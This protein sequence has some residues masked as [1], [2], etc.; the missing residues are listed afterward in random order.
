MRKSACLFIIGLA[1]H[2]SLG[3]GDDQSDCEKAGGVWNDP[4]C[5]GASHQPDGTWKSDSKVDAGM[6]SV[7]AR[8]AGDPG[9]ESRPPADASKPQDAFISE[10]RSQF[11]GDGFDPKGAK[12]AY[13]ALPEDSKEEALRSLKELADKE[14]DT[15]KAKQLADLA[16]EL[17]FGDEYRKAEGTA[18]ISARD[19]LIKKAEDKGLLSGTEQAQM[20]LINKQLAEKSAPSTAGGGTQ[21]TTKP[22][23]YR[24]INGK[25]VPT[26]LSPDGKTQYYPTQNEGVVAISRDG[27]RSY[28]T[29]P[30][31]KHGLTRGQD[32]SY[33]QSGNR[34]VSNLE[35][36]EARG[37]IHRPG[38][39]KPP[40]IE[41]G[42]INEAGKKVVGFENSQGQWVEGTPEANSYSKANPPKGYEVKNGRLVPLEKPKP[43]PATAP[44]PE[45]GPKLVP[46]GTS[47][48]GDGKDSKVVEM[49]PQEKLAGWNSWVSN[50][51]SG[52]GYPTQPKDGWYTK[53]VDW[54]NI[55]ARARDEGFGPE[56]AAILTTDALRSRSMDKHMYNLAPQ[57]V[58]VIGA[59]GRTTTR[60]PWFERPGELG[61]GSYT[62]EDWYQKTK[63]KK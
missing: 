8:S 35:A 47:P 44:M 31:E 30:E 3:W 40:A 29:E 19:A 16:A 28:T 45:T 46:I 17:E 43:A 13:A 63:G 7:G 2:G 23:E 25:R 21:L 51:L 57:Q 18:L 39:N 48:K 52:A 32:G 1:L 5:T 10:I 53:N 22:G 24:E 58:P 38:G 49:V 33:S 26:Y 61:M 20:R 55:Y 41:Y 4:D 27:G 36:P 12:N 34:T 56:A 14:S 37:V 42:Y 9:G 54:Q 15:G 50:Y 60:A 62:A 59:P 6:T 11:N